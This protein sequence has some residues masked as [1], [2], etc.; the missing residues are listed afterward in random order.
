MGRLSVPSFKPEADLSAVR[1]IKIV[2]ILLEC[3]RHQPF[4]ALG[5]LRVLNR[6]ASLIT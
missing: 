5:N 3:L 6:I 1:R 2:I 4:K